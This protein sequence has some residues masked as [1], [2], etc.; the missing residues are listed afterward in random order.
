MFISHSCYSV[1]GA[2]GAREIYRML[3]TLLPILARS[4]GHRSEPSTPQAH[5]LQSRSNREVKA[6]VNGN[7]HLFYAR[8]AP[9]A[10][11]M[12][13]RANPLRRWSEDDNQRGQ[14]D[15]NNGATATS[16]R[17]IRRLTPAQQHLKWE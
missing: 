1:Y 11:Y 10:I 15:K 4:A 6:V 8:S 13:S 14:L 7:I 5:V 9:I 16:R 17:T 3:C 2:G 12:T